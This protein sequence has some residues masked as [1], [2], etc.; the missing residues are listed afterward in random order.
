[1]LL[2]SAARPT[3]PTENTGEW[4]WWYQDEQ[5]AFTSGAVGAEELVGFV[6][7]HPNWFERP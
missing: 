7:A 5:G 4:H 1:M 3:G 2:L 6:E